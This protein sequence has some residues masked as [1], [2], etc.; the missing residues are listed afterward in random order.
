MIK[1]LALLK[2]LAHFDLMAHHGG[3]VRRS[4]ARLQVSYRFSHER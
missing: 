1:P 3:I 2:T 4:G